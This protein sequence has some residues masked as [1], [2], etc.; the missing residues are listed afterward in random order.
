MHSTSVV[1][2]TCSSATKASIFGQAT[3]NGSAS[4]SYE[5]DVVDNGEPGS[6]DHYRIRL[7]NGYDSGDHKLSGGN[8]QIH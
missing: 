4:V 8:I 3:L 6:N 1:S 7:S 5:I 2:I